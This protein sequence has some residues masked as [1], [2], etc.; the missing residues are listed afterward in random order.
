MEIA[1]LN[2]SVLRIKG[3]TT[4][5]SINPSEASGANAALMLDDSIYLLSSEETVVLQGP[6]EYEVGG[7]KITGTR[8]DKGVLYSMN[9]EGL[10]IIIG[11][12]ATL[13]AMQHKL[14]EHMVVISLCDEPTDAAFLTSLALNVVLFYG[15]K[16]EEIANGFAKENVK[17]MNKYSVALNK[18][19][20]EVETVLLS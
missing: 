15:E 9:M 17:Q 18:L 20:V 1:L 5:F 11:K 8:G 14:K 3:K 12:I 19:P 7:V 2:K 13:S 6:G 10:D 16:A 4:T